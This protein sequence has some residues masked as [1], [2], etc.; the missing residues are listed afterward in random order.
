MNKWDKRYLDLA[1]L[2]ASWSKDPSTKVGGCIIDENGNPVSFGFNGFPRGM[3]DSESRLEDRTFKY[4]HTLHSED[5]CMSFAN[6][7]Y[8]EGCTI[9]ITHPPCSSCLCKMKQRKLTKVVCLDGGE[10]F[11]SRWKTDDVLALSEELGISI[12]IYEEND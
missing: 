7:T 3:N 9:Y 6:R 11:K 8:F 2:V 1:K 4:A 5:N 10:D 12:K